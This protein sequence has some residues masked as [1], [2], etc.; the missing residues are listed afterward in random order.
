L[1]KKSNF[2]KLGESKIQSLVR[3]EAA[4]MQARLLISCGIRNYSQWFQRELNEVSDAL[5]R[6]NDQDDKESTHI[7]QT[8]CPSQIPEHFTIVPLPNKISLWL[9][10]LL[11]KLPEKHHFNE[12][13]T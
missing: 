12:I 5:S 2:S 1:A 4:Q 10:A 8:C 11:Q 13:H 6:D 7:F 9:I 3:I